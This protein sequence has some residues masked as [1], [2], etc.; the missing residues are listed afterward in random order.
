M[1]FLLV[2]TLYAKSLETADFERGLPLYLMLPSNSSC[3][4]QLNVDCSCV[5]SSLEIV[6][7]DLALKFYL[8]FLFFSCRGKFHSTIAWNFTVH[9]VI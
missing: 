2:G 4:S 6:Y 5:P 7:S 1:D 3:L 9:F 8:V